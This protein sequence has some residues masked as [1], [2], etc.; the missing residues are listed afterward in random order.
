MEDFKNLA[1]QMLIV[2]FKIIEELNGNKEYLM[3]YKV[4]FAGCDKNEKNEVFPVQGWIVSPC[5]EKERDS[6]L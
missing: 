1:S 6:I 2:P 5:T 4:G 3:K